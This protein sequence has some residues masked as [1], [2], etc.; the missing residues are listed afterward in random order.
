[1]TE[2]T[3]RQLH[4]AEVALRTFARSATGPGDRPQSLAVLLSEYDRRAERIEALEAEGA[5]VR[6]AVRQV[7]SAMADVVLPGTSGEVLVALAELR[8]AARCL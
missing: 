8:A 2:T 7:D 4:V 5:R 1:M 3:A 6:R